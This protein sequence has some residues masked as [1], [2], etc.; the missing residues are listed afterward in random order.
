MHIAEN[1]Q[2]ADLMISRSGAGTI[3]EELEFEVP[4]ILIPYPNSADQHQ[5]KN[6]E[7]MASTVGGAIKSV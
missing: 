3:A 1:R 5:D 6:A 4:G 7:F 2:A